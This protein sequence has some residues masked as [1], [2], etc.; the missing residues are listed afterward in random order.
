MKK[1]GGLWAAL[2]VAPCAMFAEGSALASGPHWSE[3]LTSPTGERMVLMPNCAQDF[4]AYGLKRCFSERLVPESF[5]AQRLMHVRQELPNLIIPLKGKKDAGGGGGGSTCGAQNSG[6]GGTPVT[7]PPVGLSATDLQAAYGLNAAGMP[8]GAGK[9]VAI[10]DACANSTI[11]SDLAAYRAQ[12]KLPALPQCGGANGVAPT[13]GGTACFGVVS[14]TGDATLPPED[15]GWAGEIALDVDMVSAACPSC[16]ILL[17]E[18]NGADDSDLDTAVNYAA[19]VADSVTNSYG[20]SEEK[21][22]GLDSAY[23]HAGVLIAAASGD[24]DYYNEIKVTETNP[25]DPTT[26]SIAYDPAGANTPASLPT[27]LSVGGSM[28]LASSTSGTGFTDS[29]WSVEVEN[30]TYPNL[31]GKFIYGGG[32]GCSVNYDTPS[33]QS[34]LDM[35]SCKKRGSVDVSA[36]S[37]YTAPDLPDGGYA[38]GGILSYAQGSWGQVV[39]TSA[40]TPFVT[41]LLTRI[42]YANQDISAIYAKASAFHDVT[43]GNNDPSKTCTDVNCNAG[44]GWDGPTGIGTPNAA[45][46]LGL[47]AGTSGGG[48]SGG[49]AGSTNDD[50][51]GSGSGSGDDAGGGGSGGGG[52]GGA[53][54]GGGIGGGGGLSG[55]DASV[56]ADATTGNGAGS[57]G[58]GGSGGGGGGGG[59]GCTVGASDSSSA[60]PG[61]LS[62]LGIAAIFAMRGRRK[63][64][65]A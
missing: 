63:R 51:G 26:W 29:V 55:E 14:Q 2:V 61:L 8:D 16:S 19:G 31:D 18:A 54:G 21:G 11:V 46:I 45:A 37:D 62:M 56:A 5:A 20:S 42:G 3:G 60:V 4:A 34:A 48:S 65:A 9:I 43:T 39:G 6:S 27:V 1:M 28:V 41:G 30:P 49:D 25:D 17:V 40:A 10:V 38:G 22:A 58:S 47:D 52:G 33:F 64:D 15:D 59:G 57:G 44:V 24:N 12:Y 7:T 50:G 32:S 23:S 53:G 36:A 13:K 35:G